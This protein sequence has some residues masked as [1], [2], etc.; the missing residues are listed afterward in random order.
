MAA[1]TKDLVARLMRLDSCAVSDACDSLSLPPA[2]T[3]IK[4]LATKELWGR[5]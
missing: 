5:A 4:R 1:S 3:G 2:V